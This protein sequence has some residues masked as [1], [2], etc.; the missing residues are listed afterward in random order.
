[1]MVTGGVGNYSYRWD[2]P[3]AATSAMV[4]G[5]MPGPVTV[6]VTDDNG[7]EMSGSISITEPA[8]LFVNVTG[9]EDV[10]CFGDSTG[11][12]SVV[13]SG[14]VPGYSYSVDSINF[15]SDTILTDL[16]AGTYEVLVMDMMGCLAS[17]TATI[18][19]PQQLQINAGR[20][21]T[22]NLG[23]PV[24]LSGL[25]FPFQRPVDIQWTPAENL[26]CD[27]CLVTSLLPTQSRFY[28]ANIIDET[29]C[30]ASD[31]IRIGV[32]KIRPI[33]IPNVF[34]PNADGVNDFFSVSG[35]VAADQIQIMRIFN[36]WGALMYE[37]RNLPLNVASSGWDGQFKNE[38]MGPGV[39]VYYILVDFIDGVSV[40]YQGDIMILK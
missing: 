24:R 32:N 9:V 26:S 31:S 34:S 3:S 5:L 37:G 13:G 1:V 40:A 22:V 27:T 36:R 17:V 12:I 18:A 11:S 23:F 25:V 2:N 21:T 20:D 4:S 33:Y 6:T 14:G 16:L 35:N 28:V 15:T 38:D 10:L 19:E 7:C 30:V 29:G 39:Y 8:G